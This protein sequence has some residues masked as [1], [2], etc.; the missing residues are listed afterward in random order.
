MH[1][2]NEDLKINNMFSEIISNL[3]NLSDIEEMSYFINYLKNFCNHYNDLS[4]EEIKQIDERLQTLQIIV[5]NNKN[6]PIN[7]KKD[8]LEIL[9]KLKQITIRLTV[10]TIISYI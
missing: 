9:K 8:L 7:Y 10:N 4:L 2:F 5:N 6:L 3:N 1:N